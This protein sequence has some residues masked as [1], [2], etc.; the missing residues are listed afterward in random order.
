MLNHYFAWALV[1]H[2]GVVGTIL[3]RVDQ[4]WVYTAA[5]SLAAVVMLTTSFSCRQDLSV[6]KDLVR[7]LTAMSGVV[8]RRLI[9]RVCNPS[10]RS[11]NPL[12]LDELGVA[13]SEP[14]VHEE[15]P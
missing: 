2:W 3:S 4:F 13:I 11:D 6:S 9:L 15:V 10:F 12:A 1:A 5:T 8:P 14:A 7:A